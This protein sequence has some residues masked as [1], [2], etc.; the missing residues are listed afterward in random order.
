[1]FT[2][3]KM[4]IFSVIFLTCCV[5]LF[6]SCSKRSRLTNSTLILTISPSSATVLPGGTQTFTVSGRSAKTDNPDIDP[7]WSLSPTTLGKLS[8]SSGKTVT[9]TAGSSEGSGKI[10]AQEGDVRVEALITV[11]AGSVWKIYNDEGAIATVWTWDSYGEWGV[12]SSS[13]TFDGNF[14]GISGI[15]EGA[16]CFKTVSDNGN[17]YAGWGIFHD[18]GVVARTNYSNGHLVFW[19]NSDAEVKVEI[20]GPKGTKK[21][22]KISSTGGAWQQISIPMSDFAGVD[23]SQIYGSFSI[24]VESSNKTFY[25]DDVK[26]TTE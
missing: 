15:P 25:V 23:F 18:G 9:F 20:E 21:S 8:S 2:R 14:T 11:T 10:I 13:A 1:M 6:I 3:Q 5:I 16:K 22:R 12:G 17:T 24:T 26:W 4:F 19:L 7:E